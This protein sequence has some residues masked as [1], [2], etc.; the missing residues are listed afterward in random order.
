MR[1]LCTPAL[2]LLTSWLLTAC[3]VNPVTGERELRLISE[4]EEI[5]LGEQ[6]YAPLK[7]MQGGEYQVDPE[8]LRYVNRVGQRVARESD[9]PRL[10]YEFTVINSDVPNA[11]ALPGGKI[12]IN[13]GLLTEFESEAELAAVL[14]HEIVHSAARHSAQQIERQLLL[15]TGV[16]AIAA[17]SSDSRYAGAIVGSAMIGAGL[18]GQRFSRSAELEADEFGTLYMHRAG[19]HPDGAVQ[20]MERF[21]QL[22]E[23]RNPNWLEGLFASHPPSRERVQA[24]QRTAARL[25][26]EGEWGRERFEQA[27]A[28]LREH[29]P[30]YDKAG[31]AR[32]RLREGDTGQAL[33]LAREARDAVP[34]EARFHALV[35]DIHHQRGETDTALEHYQEARRREDGYFHHHLMIGLLEAERERDSQAR[36]ALNRSLELLPTATAHLQLGHIERR[37]GQRAAAIEHYRVAAQSESDA[38]GQAREAL[39][40]MGVE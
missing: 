11:W 13:R 28:T 4:S 34:R 35:G 31:E 32:S 17:A 7:Q 16:I 6:N 24:N 3:A 27:L 10:P 21:V 38:G 23:G 40:E 5:R 29:K 39:R 36:A 20:L 18:I 37:A 9:R 12:A 14:G 26:R 22:S 8:L 2:L 33:R 15:Q 19:Y 25:G 30:A 1:R